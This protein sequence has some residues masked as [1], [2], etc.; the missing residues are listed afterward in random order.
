M[1]ALRMRHAANLG[2]QPVHSLGKAR[3]FGCDVRA[4]NLVFDAVNRP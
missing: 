1:V 4:G 2:D 3:Q